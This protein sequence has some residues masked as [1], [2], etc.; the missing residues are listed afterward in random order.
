[1]KQNK[2]QKM[3]ENIKKVAGYMDAFGCE[4][5]LIN[6]ELVACYNLDNGR[7][8]IYNQK[9]SRKISRRFE[10]LLYW[11]NWKNDKVH[12]TDNVMNIQS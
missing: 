3:L 10:T 11:D 9:D 1:M 4:Y 2:T 6:S 8:N 7:F 12:I 5:L